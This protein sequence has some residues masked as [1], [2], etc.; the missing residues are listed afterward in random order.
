MSRNSRWCRETSRHQREFHRPGGESVLATALTKQPDVS[1]L[2]VGYSGVVSE[3]RVTYSRPMSAQHPSPAGGSIVGGPPDPEH[4]PTASYALAPSVTAALT[5]RVLATSGETVEVRSPL[6]GAPL[7]HIPQSS[8]A[9]V[10]EAFVR[11]RRAQALWAR[12]SL[13][14]RAA[15]LLRLHDL[16][17]DRQDE[18]IDLIVWE[19]GQGPQARVRR[20][21]AHR[22]DGPLLRPHRPPA[23][24]HPA[25]AGRRP[26]PHPGRGQPDPQGRRRDHLA[27]E[28]PVHDG[29]VRRAARAARRQRRRRQA[30]RPDHAVGAAGRRAARAGRLP[31]GPVAGRRG[32]R[33]AGRYGDHR[34]RRLRLLHRLDGHRQARRA[35]T[36]PTG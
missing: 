14:E 6:D 30:G 33:R 28:L 4:D 36:A 31:R 7:A 15:M 17:L 10:E 35:G 8:D 27:V 32:P 20:A 24:R 3:T 19:S 13:D 29:A 34:P 1:N 22:A 12:T 2:S 25:Q 18:I 5:R 23:P 11:A 21:A 26:R 9:D 16:V